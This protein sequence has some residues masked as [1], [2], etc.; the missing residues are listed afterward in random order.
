MI[1]SKESGCFALEE[2]IPSDGILCVCE[3]RE[4]VGLRQLG[5]VDGAAVLD[6]CGD[7]GSKLRMSAGALEGLLKVRDDVL[8]DRVPGG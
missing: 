6:V 3:V 8:P 1:V 4:E 2:V 5:H 7:E